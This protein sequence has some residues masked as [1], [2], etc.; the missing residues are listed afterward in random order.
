[1][2]SRPTPT[3]ALLSASDFELAAEIMTSDRNEAILILCRAA[4]FE[5]A[6]VRAL[7]R[8][9]PE[10]HG[11]VDMQMDQLRQ[12]YAKLTQSTAQRVLRFWMVRKTA[13]APANYCVQTAIG[14]TG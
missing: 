12:D 2:G 5:W 10:Q 11:I 6:T 13:N 7:L 9:R 8:S 1:M 14:Q 4:R 3:I